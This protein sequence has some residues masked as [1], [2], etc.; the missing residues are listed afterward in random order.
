MSATRLSTCCCD[1]YVVQPVLPSQRF[2]AF[3]EIFDDAGML[4]GDDAL[5]RDEQMLR[6]VGIVFFVDETGTAGVYMG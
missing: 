4:D 2:E 5:G 1:A 3:V 6:N